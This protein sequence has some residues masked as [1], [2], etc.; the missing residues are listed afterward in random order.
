MSSLNHKQREVLQAK[1]RIERRGQE[2]LH[3]FWQ[4]LNFFLYK[5]AI[6]SVLESRISAYAL[7]ARSAPPITVYCPIFGPLYKNE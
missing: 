5:F 2:S 7:P 1:S 6:V 4:S 3:T